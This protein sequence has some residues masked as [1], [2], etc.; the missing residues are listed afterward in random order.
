LNDNSKKQINYTGID[1]STGLLD[2]AK[3]E[4]PDQKF[5]ETDMVAFVENEKQQKY[6]LIVCIASFQHIFGKKERNICVK[7]FYKILNYEGI[8][9]MLN[10]SFSK[11]FMKKFRKSIFLSSIKSIFSNREFNDLM[12]KWK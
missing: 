3:K 1:I 5:I 8:I 12:I 11:R 9:L 4:N 7:N 6:D 2:I 10:W